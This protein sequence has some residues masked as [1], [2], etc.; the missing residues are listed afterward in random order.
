MNRVSHVQLS[1]RC[2]LRP[3]CYIAILFFLF[4]NTLLTSVFQNDLGV[5]P[6]Y[7]ITIYNC[8]KARFLSTSLLS[9]VRVN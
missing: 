1:L 7:R 5:M 6:F 8:Y 3:F 2:I 4:S 9:L